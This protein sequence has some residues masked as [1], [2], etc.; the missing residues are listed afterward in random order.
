LRSLGVGPEVR[1]A[2]C[3]ERSALW[4]IGALAI[5]K[6]GGAYVALDSASPPQRLSWLLADSEA[7]LLLT[8]E[9]L[10]SRLPPS[11]TPRVLLDSEAHLIFARPHTPP[12]STSSAEHL[13]Y[14][15]YTSGSTGQPKPVGVTHRSLMNLV[16]WHQRQYALTPH[17]RTTQVAGTAFDASVWELWPPLASGASLHI[18]GDEERASPALLLHWLHSRAITHCFLPTPLAEAVLAEA[19]WP[20]DMALRTLL[21]GG[22]RLRQRPRAGLPLQLVNHYG[23]TESTVVTTCAPVAEEGTEAELPPIGRPIANTQVYV[24]DRELQ[25]VPVGVTG[26]L[27]VGGTGLARGYLGRPALTAERFLPHP[28]SSEPGARL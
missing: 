19:A 25:P 24:L 4:A 2:L 1:V 12:R 3:L 13:A 21:T 9:A 8:T 15:I 22:D 7:L 20:Q 11:A 14:V 17:S 26:E 18:P 27:Y 23:P 28:F 5:L 16:T 6:A 10:S